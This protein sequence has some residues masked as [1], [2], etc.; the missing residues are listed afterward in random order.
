[1]GIGTRGIAPSDPIGVTP[2]WWIDLA[3]L[4]VRFCRNAGIT[5]VHSFLVTSIC[6]SSTQGV[7][8]GYLYDGGKFWSSDIP[9][10][11]DSRIA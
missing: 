8:N 11:D 3:V 2:L 10:C 7:G 9:I 4:N 6:C 1:M 5:R